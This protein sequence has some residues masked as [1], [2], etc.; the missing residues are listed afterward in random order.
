MRDY[1]QGLE[2]KNSQNLPCFWAFSLCTACFPGLGLSDQRQGGALYERATEREW[3]YA[4]THTHSEKNSV[5]AALDVWLPLYRPHAVAG[6]KAPALKCPE[7][8]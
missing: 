5:S 7:I 1:R 8:E 4:K 6:E 3:A 2:I